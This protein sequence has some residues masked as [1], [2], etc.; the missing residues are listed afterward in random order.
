MWLAR[1]A[2]PAPA[3]SRGLAHASI[4]VAAHEYGHTG[5]PLPTWACTQT[6]NIH[7]AENP[8]PVRLEQLPEVPGA[9]ILHNV[10]TEQECDQFV[11]ITEDLGYDPDAPVSLPYSFRHMHNANWI[12]HETVTDIIFRRAFPALPAEA[13]EVAPEAVAVG[14]NAR[15]RCYRYSNGDYF[16]PHTDGSWPGSLMVQSSA[17]ELELKWDAFGD[18]WSQF[19][20]LL[21]LSDDYE[22]G[23]TIFHVS[24]PS[25]ITKIGVR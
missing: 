13:V 9:F 11:K 16:K 20:F 18:R 22:G 21:L 4:T 23:R 17:G 24:N 6:G 2:Q 19:T 14:I 3:L 5:R 10:L 1:A 25:E 7:F 15:F 12:V 8:E